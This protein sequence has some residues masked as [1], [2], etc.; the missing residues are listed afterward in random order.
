MFKHDGSLNVTYVPSH[1]PTGQYEG[2]RALTYDGPDTNGK[3]TKVFAYM[4]VP[5]GY[6]MD[7]E[8][9]SKIPAMVL[10]HGGLGYAFL[11]WVKQWNDRGYAAISICNVGLFPVR[12]GAGDREGAIFEDWTHE[13]CGVFAQDGYTVPPTYDDMQLSDN[14]SIDSMWMYHAVGQVL[15]AYDVIAALGC[16]D[17]QK[18]GLMGIS[19]GSVVTSIAI[20]YDNSYA[21]AMPV[22]G[23]GYLDEALSFMRFKFNVPRSKQMWLAQERF[24][25]VNMPVL[26]LCMNDD[27]A[28]SANSNSKSYAD[29]CKN[30]SLTQLSIKSGWVHGHSCSWDTDNYECHEI[31]KFADAMTRDKGSFTYITQQEYNKE[32]EQEGTLSVIFT[33]ENNSSVSYAATLYYQTDYEYAYTFPADI[34][35]CYLAHK[36]KTAEATVTSKDGGSFLAVARIPEN[37]T[38]CYLEIAAKTDNIKYV[39]SSKFYS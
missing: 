18:V 37:T 17:S 24:S 31:Y 2:I 20:G 10:V 8:Y 36:W 11:E 7:S 9:D 1:Y 29:T 30:N 6:D 16:V 33:G 34:H 26:W 19:W 35:K 38:Y 28:F 23:S 27:F 5:A 3:K 39:V 13:L 12:Q 32:P 15:R 22:Y 4:G 21:F 25:N 14:Q